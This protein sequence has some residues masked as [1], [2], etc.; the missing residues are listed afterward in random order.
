M[1]ALTTALAA[2]CFVRAFGIS[3]LALPRSQAAA[4]ADESPVSMLVPQASLAVLC[5]GLGLFPGVALRTL[6]GVIAS[7]PGAPPGAGLIQGAMGMRAGFSG[8]D[9]LLRVNSFDHVVPALLGAALLGGLVM[10]AWAANRSRT[11]VRCGAD[12]GLR[13]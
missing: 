7:L 3:F 1:L 9:G 12:L 13:W 8:T 2:A 5:L 4:D 6:G 11:A 10:A